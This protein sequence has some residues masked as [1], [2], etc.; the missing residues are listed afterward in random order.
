M[1]D[2]E[3]LILRGQLR[4]M[5]ALDTIAG[6]VLPRHLYQGVRASLNDGR[7]EIINVIIPDEPEEE[8]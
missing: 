6:E 4:I 3:I 1:N 5:E 7:A 8:E 2:N